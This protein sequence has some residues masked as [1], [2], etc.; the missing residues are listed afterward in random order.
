MQVRQLP[1]N[2]DF[3][4]ALSLS[5]RCH[6]ASGHAVVEEAPASELGQSGW[7]CSGRRVTT[8]NAGPVGRTPLETSPAAAGA[9]DKLQMDFRALLCGPCSV[10]WCATARAPRGASIVWTQELVILNTTVPRCSLTS[11]MTINARKCPRSRLV[12]LL[13]S[14]STAL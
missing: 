13:L 14:P 8:P 5:R 3:S 4:F 12:S 7:G 10:L 6:W 1:T 9:K 2:C 11:T